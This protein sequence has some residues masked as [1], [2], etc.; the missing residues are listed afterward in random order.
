LKCGVVKMIL[1]ASGNK[2]F[3]YVF[4]ENVLEM[5]EKEE[6]MAGNF[7]GPRKDGK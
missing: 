6:E 4:E 2:S 7:E 1:C 5:R 3:I